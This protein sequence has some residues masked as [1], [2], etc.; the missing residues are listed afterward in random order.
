MYRIFGESVERRLF[1]WAALHSKREH[2]FRATMCGVAGT[3]V[4]TMELVSGCVSIP[5]MKMFD[6]VIDHKRPMDRE[7][8]NELIK[9][10]S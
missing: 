10:L 7:E 8:K 9:E 5:L 6:S 3:I 1:V 2:P 4:S